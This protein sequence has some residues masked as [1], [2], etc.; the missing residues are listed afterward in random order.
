MEQIQYGLGCMPYEA[1]ER[2]YQFNDLINC[3]TVYPDEYISP[4]PDVRL[5]QG[6][7]MMCN[8][9]ALSMARY[10]YELNDSGNARL[11]SPSYIYANRSQYDYK[12]EGMNTRQ[13]LNCLVSNGSCYIGSFNKLGTYAELS[14]EYNANKQALDKEAY[15]Y[16]I[17]SYYALYDNNQIKQSILTTGCAIAAYNVYD[18]WY[19]VRKD[20]KI[21]SNYG[22]NHGGHCILIVGWTKENE[23]IILNSWGRSWGDNGLGYIPMSI[24]RNE[25]WCA[26]DNVQEIF[27]TTLK[28]CENHWARRSIDKAVQTGILKGYDDGL[29]LPDNSITRAEACAIVAKLDGYDG[30]ELYDS[31]FSDVTKNDWF[32]TYVEYCSLRNRV[33]GYSDG[34][35][36]PLVNL[37]RAE[38]CKILALL[39]KIKVQAEI[40]T[41][42]FN[43]VNKTH[44]GCR[45]I[46]AMYDS[47]YIS[48][49]DDNTFKPD[50]YITRAE[51]IT[52]INRM[53]LLDI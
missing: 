52:I 35:F 12:G 41:T 7:T 37:T 5:N 33:A 50:G 2:D 47:G 53:G 24:P 18:N 25:A 36:R 45:F 29:F 31:N 51:F 9:F 42:Y 27:F 32:F 17:S 10:I 38:A 49:Y 39:G 34:T 26:L 22:T 19:N 16:R 43:D 40:K 20:G 11:L 30:T 13:S 6:G 3:A 1:D 48:G 4:I 14:A 44:W 23:W 28:D 21:L 15:P 46:N 8:A